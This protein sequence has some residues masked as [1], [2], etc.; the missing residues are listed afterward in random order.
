MLNYIYYLLGYSEDQI[1][2]GEQKSSQDNIDQNNIHNQERKTNK[3]NKTNK[4]CPTI[5]ELNEKKNQIFRKKII[6]VK[7]QPDELRNMKSKLKKI[8]PQ[9]KIIIN[10]FLNELVEGRKRILKI[11]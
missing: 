2:N 10:S 9:K 5:K 4:Y 1:Q 6:Y 11:A 3:I 7:P 8:R